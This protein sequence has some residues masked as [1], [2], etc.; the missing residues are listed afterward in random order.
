[1]GISVRQDGSY[2]QACRR[3]ASKLGF[4]VVAVRCKAW[5]LQGALQGLYSRPR[6]GFVRPNFAPLAVLSRSC[7]LTFYMSTQRPEDN[8]KPRD[9]KEDF[10]SGRVN[11]KYTDPCRDAANASMKCMDDNSYDRESCLEFFQVY[12]DCKRTWINQRKTDRQAGRAR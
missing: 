5:R 2:G 12:R 10:H 3:S 7:L 6:G 9:W 11:T 1:M 8:L 4:C